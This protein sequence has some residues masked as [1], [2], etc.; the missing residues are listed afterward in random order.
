MRSD[1]ESS[2]TATSTVTR[3]FQPVSSATAVSTSPASTAIVTPLATQT[4]APTPA[5]ITVEDQALTED[6]QLTIGRIVSQQPGWAVI[7]DD[8]SGEAGEILGFIQVPEG[9]SENIVV[10]IEPL[11]ATPTLYAMFHLDEGQSGTFEFPGPDRP[12][13]SGNDIVVDSFIVDIQ[14]YFPDVSVNDQ[15]VADDGLVTVRQ[16]MAAEPS[17]LV[18]HADERGEPGRMLAYAPLKIGINENVTLSIDWRTAPPILHAV[19]YVDEGQAGQFEESDINRPIMLDGEPVAA[20]FEVILPPD[21]YVLDQP[22]VGGD[23]VIERVISYESNWLVIYN[24]NEEETLGNIIGW[25]LLETGI[26]AQVIVTVTE[27][28]VTP[29]L[30]AMLHE[31]LEDIGE[32]EF[33]R[34][35]PVV[36]YEDG[37]HP[38]TFRTDTGNYLITRDQP[39]SSSNVIT[40]PLAVVDE[41]AWVVVRADEEGELGEILGRRWIQSGL[42]REIAVT[43]DPDLVT[44]TLHVVLH[45]DAGTSRIFDFPEG[46]DVPFQ[47]NRTVIRAP[48]TLSQNNGQ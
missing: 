7:Y 24:Q 27:A 12:A 29:I 26:N 35:D 36:I 18:L 32:F 34:T 8:D 33:P 39:L 14:I 31:D 16:A 23:I 21:I 5:T 38:Y 10:S 3:L 43:L 13:R 41:D 20:A 2:T 37:I 6:G 15:E 42:N 44:P 45:L 11:E 47:R 48:F 25:S 19:L 30:Y 28:A 40:V 9:E 17:W 4:A 46:L 22:V 1:E